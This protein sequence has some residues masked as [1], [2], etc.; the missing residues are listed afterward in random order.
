ME[1]YESYRI[2]VNSFLAE[3]VDGFGVLAEGVDRVGGDIDLDV[4]IAYFANSGPQQLGWT[5]E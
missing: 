4:L 2:T 1:L 5:S 3:G